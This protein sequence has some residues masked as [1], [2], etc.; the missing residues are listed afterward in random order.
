MF[1]C[2]DCRESKPPDDF[3]RH[4]GRRTGRGNICKPCTNERNRRYRAENPEKVKD[5]HR[6]WYLRNTD[7]MIDKVRKWREMNREK[8]RES[9]RLSMARQRKTAR[10][11]ILEAYGGQCVCCGESEPSFLALDHVNNDGYE[12]RKVT[13]NSSH[14]VY[15]DAMRRGFPPDYQLLCHN[16]NM[17]KSLNGGTCPHQ[18]VTAA[19]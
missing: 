2:S 9:A 7:H 4:R 10:A 12:R 18:R 19:A 17:G 15:R 14:V 5:Q 13:G 8:V 1:V 16:C 6:D 3:P 11:A